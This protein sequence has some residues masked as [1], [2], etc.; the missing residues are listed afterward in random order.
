[1]DTTATTLLVYLDGDGRLHVDSSAP[2]VVQKTWVDPLLFLPS[3]QHQFI[4]V[5]HLNCLQ[6]LEQL[7]YFIRHPGAI[8]TEESFTKVV[9][10]GSVRGE[11]LR[12]FLH[13]LTWLHAPAVALSTFWD[14]SK[15]AQHQHHVN[16]FLTFLSGVFS[17]PWKLVFIRLRRSK[18]LCFLC[19]CVRA[20]CK[21]QL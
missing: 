9:Q 7:F 8:I 2:S 21:E 18:M 6:V 16:D 5:F 1:M 13:E 11:P 10:F 15:Q 3:S 4:P 12:R 17:V 20:D 19:V 14:R